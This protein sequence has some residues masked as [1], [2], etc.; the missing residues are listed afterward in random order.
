MI[1]RIESGKKYILLSASAVLFLI[2]LLN[3]V[4]WVFP[5]ES[6]GADPRDAVE[7]KEA[8]EE[9][10]F[11][12]TIF[13]R[14]D[15]KAYREVINLVD[16]Y[17]EKH[18]LTE[19][20]IY[21]VHLKATAH[22]A[23]KETDQ[24]I[25]AY[26]K[27]LPMV[28]KL[29]NVSRRKFAKVFFILGDLY[30]EIGKKDEAISFIEEGLALEPQ[31][32][33][34]QIILGEY[35]VDAG[36]KERAV[37]HYLELLAGPGLKEEEGVVIR[38]KLKRLHVAAEPPFPYQELARQPFYKGFTIRILPINGV[39]PAIQTEDICPLLESKFLVRCEVL[40]PITW[41]EKKILDPTRDQY[42]GDHILDLLEK[43]YPNPKAS[44]TLLIAF[45][46][47]DIFGPKT[48]FVFSWQ[49]PSRGTAVLSSKRFIVFRKDYEP[50]VISTRRVAI[51]FIST[52]ANLL[53][54]GRT[55]KPH[56]PTSYPDGLDDFLLK[57][58]KLCEQTIVERDEFLKMRAGRPGRFEPGQLREIERVYE[59]YSFR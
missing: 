40:D 59:K 54:F 15:A 28:R 34:A 49:T 39:D 12:N 27:T 1:D 7:S 2:L 4:T 33:V 5:P 37:S 41:D 38:T 35:Y 18:P 30:H 48:N 53:G 23:L 58:S 3:G 32:T 31:S 57:S 25:A 17:F 42:D 6:K 14:F 11:L 55:T 9:K 8:D 24:A 10:A 20:N 52:I 19:K 26:E 29:H 43:T 22:L 47:K 51:Q 16:R 50:E 56:C 45:T 44:N 21:Y 13:E 36:K 46:G